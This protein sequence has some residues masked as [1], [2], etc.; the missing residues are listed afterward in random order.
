MMITLGAREELNQAAH[1]WG[2]IVFH[3]VI[4]QKFAHKAIGEEAR[5][6]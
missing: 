6:V 1:G 4:N 3:D 5:T 2:C